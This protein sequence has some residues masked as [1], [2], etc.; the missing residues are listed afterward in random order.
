MHNNSRPPDL[1]DLAFEGRNKE[2]GAYTLRKK[3]NR[4]LGI[5]TIIGI[6][7]V[8]LIAII[9]FL[10]YYFEPIPLIEGDMMYEVDYTGLMPLPDEEMSK[11]LQ[12][13]SKPEQKVLQ[14]PI[15][16]DSVR[17][18][19]PVKIEDPP[20]KK[21]TE[22]IKTKNDSLERPGGS[23]LGTGT[24]DDTGLA[25]TIDV[26]P[27]F[28]GGDEARL[29]YLRQHIRYPLPALKSKIQGVVM[30]VFIVEINGS[31]SN[32]E[33]NKIIG[34]G[35]DEEAIRVTKEMPAWSPGKRNGRPVRVM[36]RMP[37]VFRIPGRTS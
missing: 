30:V 16:S 23:G 19:E 35:C 29:Y 4:Y 37:I 22:D 18:D 26:F 36:V 21:D 28:P 10:I 5:S 7:G 27:R 1:T 32:V 24:G 8:L 14:A 6:S 12:A 20:E 2:Y 31:I 13:L 11:L 34:G 15:V 9:P 17:P 25:T 3:Y 33:V